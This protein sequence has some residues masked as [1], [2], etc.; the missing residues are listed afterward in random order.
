MRQSHRRDIIRLSTAHIVAGNGRAATRWAIR[1]HRL[2]LPGRIVGIKRFFP[3]IRWA[4]PLL[5]FG[6][7]FLGHMHQAF[8]QR[9]TDWNPYNIDNS[10]MV[11]I[12]K[13]G[14]RQVELNSDGTAEFRGRGISESW[15][16]A[17]FLWNLVEHRDGPLEGTALQVSNTEGVIVAEWPVVIFNEQYRILDKWEEIN[18][19]VDLGFSKRTRPQ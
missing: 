2:N 8:F 6:L 5:V 7:P 17:K 15:K 9:L 11:G 1:A 10:A 16:K 19:L 13:K 12:W 18:S 4:L 3:R 14:S